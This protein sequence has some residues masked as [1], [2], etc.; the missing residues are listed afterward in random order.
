MQ[1]ETEKIS[2][3]KSDISLIKAFKSGDDLAIGIIFS[4]YAPFLKAKAAAFDC[5]YYYEDL[6][7]E[8]KIGLFKAALHYNEESGVPFSSYATVCAY[9][10]MLKF[11]KRAVIRQQENE[12][13]SRDIA[14]TVEALPLEDLF[15]GDE[16]AETIGK[17]IESELSDFEKQVLN[18]YF[19]KKSYAEIAEETNCKV[20]SVDNALTRIKQK[21]ARK[22]AFKGQ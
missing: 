16:G 2:S 5:S 12:V 14:K 13:S 1:N 10:E 19:A 21:I 3:E 17:I 15:I 6:M 4:R 8:G 7:Q 9:H 22:L 11:Y 20:K 18:C